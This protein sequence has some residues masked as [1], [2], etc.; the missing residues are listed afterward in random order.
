M[1]TVHELNENELD[2]LKWN[3]FY[4][5]DIDHHFAYDYPHEIPNEVIFE[6]FGHISFVEEDFSS[7]L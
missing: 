6:H 2:E 4:D 3:Y 7:N 1:K 5:E